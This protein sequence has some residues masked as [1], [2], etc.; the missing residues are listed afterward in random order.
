L[1]QIDFDAP[2]LL[3]HGFLYP[4]DRHLHAA[5]H[6]DFVRWMDDMDFGANSIAEARSILGELETLLNSYGLRLNSGKTRIL[7]AEDAS[8]H[9]WIQ[10]NRQLTIAMNLLESAQSRGADAT[11]VHGVF[12]RR[13][14]GFQAAEKSGNWEKIQKRYFSFFGRLLDPVLE[15]EVPGFL[16]DHPA[17]RRSIFTYYSRLGFSRDR[18]DHLLAFLSDGCCADDASL[19]GAVHTMVEW[20]VPD[21]QTTIRELIQLGHSLGN[22]SSQTV[23]SVV[24]G[25][26]LLGKYGS[27]LDLEQLGDDTFDVWGKSQWAS[28]QIAASTPLF[29]SVASAR[30]RG[31][32]VRGGLH[33]GVA[34]LSHLDQLA[35]LESLDPQLR[36]YLFHPPNAGWNYPFSKVVLTV[37]LM[38][39]RLRID[40]RTALRGV[41]NS[42]IIDPTYRRLLQLAPLSRPAESTASHS[43]RAAGERLTV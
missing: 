3:A 33:E 37:W 34:V 30:I 43:E 19:F 18:L 23:T 8:R 26:L 7:S 16:S 41:C 6:G 27:Q 21:E 35:T 12:T 22:R 11:E 31:A 15:S 13:Y 25:L 10:E 42:T 40:D 32:I 1:P 5:T 38:T 36:A 17:L 9:F 20:A 14:G 39:G 4:V 24:A 2:R 29:A 28:R